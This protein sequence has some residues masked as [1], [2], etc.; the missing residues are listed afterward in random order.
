MSSRGLAVGSLAPLVMVVLFTPK[1]LD[2]AILSLLA[3]IVIL[4]LPWRRFERAVALVAFVGLCLAFGGTALHLVLSSQAWSNPTSSGLAELG[5]TGAGQ[6]I[7][8]T[9][10]RT[11]LLWNSRQEVSLSFEARASS[12]PLNWDWFRN[13]PNFI[14]EPRSDPDGAAYTRITTPRSSD[15]FL[16]RTFSDGNRMAGRTFRVAMLVRSDEDIPSSPCRGLWLQ[17][18]GEGAARSCVP[19]EVSDAW[20][21]IGGEWTV[22]INTEATILRI[23]LNNLDGY[24]Y[25]IRDVRLWEREDDGWHLRSPLLPEAPFV[26]FHWPHQAGRPQQ[27]LPFL[28]GPVWQRF[29]FTSE[30]PPEDQLGLNQVEVK[31]FARQAT[32]KE[33]GVEVR[34][35]R[36]RTAPIDGLA[37]PFPSPTRARLWFPHPNLAG[38]AMVAL[39]GTA[40][41]L[42]VGPLRATALG[43]AF[44]VVIS[45][46]SRAAILGV[47]SIALL[48]LLEAALALRGRPRWHI[49]AIGGLLLLGAATASLGA[50]ELLHDRPNSVARWEIWR[51][52]VWA[53]LE[54]PF[55][56]LAGQ[57]I[58]FGEYWREAY[59]GS[60]LEV[61]QHAHN[62]WLQMAASHGTPGLVSALWFSTS[63]VLIGWKYRRWRGLLIV[64]PVLVANLFDFTMLFS[65]VYLPLA[66]A[67]G[68]VR[69]SPSSVKAV[70]CSS[71]AAS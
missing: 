70:H 29:E 19:F 56:G 4:S 68:V 3:A 9:G 32:E 2:P 69:S 57:D 6:A 26:S 31:L 7:T 16:M 10:Q 28:P 48:A 37:F 39:G 34:N 58:G 61:V 51:L 67:L 1:A 44:I 11:W 40:V 42:L 27:G 24:S 45:T 20:Q 22:P 36:L 47:G 41:G 46:G 64:V 66:A 50:A 62:Y 60:G 5:R 15:P 53:W 12:P 38:H 55:A 8:R 54:H 71:T 18:W 59:D 17:V 35:A 30:A 21:E 43:L 63:L 49:G 23:V 33:W 13:D 14:L 52:S 25:D 65:W